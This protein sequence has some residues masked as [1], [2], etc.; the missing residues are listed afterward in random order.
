MM[1]KLNGYQIMELDSGRSTENEYWDWALSAGHYS[2]ALASDDLHYP[3]RTSR[4]AVR[5]S[6]LCT[7]SATYE[8]IRRTLLEGCH[9]SM[10][11]PD[12]GRGDWDV[13]YEGNRNLPYISH[14]GLDGETIHMDLSEPADSIKVTGQDHTCLTIVRDTCRV[15]YMMSPDDSYARL[16]AWFPDGEVI[17]TNPF[18]RYDASISDGP[19]EGPGHSVNILLTILFN[20]ILLMLAAGTGVL[21]VKTIRK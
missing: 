7:P 14:I 21:L 12:Y 3:D 13:K 15:E 4:I 11:V 16:T 9:Y 8:D 2:T 6:F 18:A 1:E 19:S 17:Y 10:R 5:C 20:L